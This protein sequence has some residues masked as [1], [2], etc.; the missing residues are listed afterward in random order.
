MFTQIWKQY[1]ATTRL[2]LS[3]IK[4]SYGHIVPRLS[5]YPISRPS[6]LRS[7]QYQQFQFQSLLFLLFLHSPSLQSSVSAAAELLTPA[8]VVPFPTLAVTGTPQSSLSIGLHFHL[9]TVMWNLHFEPRSLRSLHTG[10]VCFP[11]DDRC[12]TLI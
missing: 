1:H 5:K 8:P 7:L 11:P 2:L 6:S 12:G 4:P 9:L 3:L 10:V